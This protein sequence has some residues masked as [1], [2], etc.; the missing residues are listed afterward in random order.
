MSADL[1]QIW[2]GLERDAAAKPT[3]SVI[4][5]LS[6]PDR[7][8]VLVGV[9]A[10]TGLRF[11]HIEAPNSGR[12]TGLPRWKEIKV[13]GEILDAAHEGI[14]VELQNKAFSKVFSALVRD[15]LASVEGVD[16]AR[17]RLQVVRGR[18]EDWHRFFRERANQA[19]TI[20][21]QRGL[22]AELWFLH[23]HLLPIM[24]PAAIDAWQGPQGGVQDYRLGGLA[25]EVKATIRGSTDRVL[26]SNERQLDPQ[27]LEHLFLFVLNVVEDPTIGETLPSLVS[28]VRSQLAGSGSPAQAFEAALRQVGYLDEHAEDYVHNYRPRGETLHRVAPGF[29]SITAPPAG[30]QRVRYELLLDSCRRYQAPLSQA[31]DLFRSPVHGSQ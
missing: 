22:F 10:S 8:Q 3:G 12:I 13:S 14:T 5:L 15:L 19:L 21:E 25:L 26:I 18:L 16:D 23:E 7:P 17:A 28:T 4:R 11:M 30:I 9:R 31:T 27:G 24:G 20:E 6:G 29:P 2:E 1:Q